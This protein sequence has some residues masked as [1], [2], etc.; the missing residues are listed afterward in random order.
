MAWRRIAN[1]PLSEPVATQL[2]D[3]YMR[4]QG[5]M[6]YIDKLVVLQLAVN[7][8]WVQ[9]SD[10]SNLNDWCPKLNFILTYILFF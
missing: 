5:E 8:S 6:S 2:T 9:E 1:K 10:T 3:A 7:Y 4:H